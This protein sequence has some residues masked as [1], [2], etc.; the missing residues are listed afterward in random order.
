MCRAQIAG[1]VAASSAPRL[2]LGREVKL[3]GNGDGDEGRTPGQGK[4]REYRP[5]CA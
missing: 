3:K 4:G 2:G 1:V 5:R